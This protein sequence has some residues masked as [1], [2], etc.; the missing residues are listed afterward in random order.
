VLLKV[1]MYIENI[2]IILG[3]Y[4]SGNATVAEVEFLE[5][6]ILKNQQEY[7]EAVK[8]YFLTAQSR[9]HLNAEEAYEKFLGKINEVKVVSIG[10]R[11]L[12]YRILKY[13]ALFVGVSV[14]SFLLYQNLN[15]QGV[16]SPKTAYDKATL[17]L[18]DGTEVVLEEHQNEVLESEDGVKI[19]NKNKV[20][21][22]SAIVAAVKGD[23]TKVAYNTLHVPVGE[24]YQVELPD[25]SK[26]W[27]NSSTSLKFPTKFV[28][29][30]R[31][32]TMDGEA[33]FE[34]EKDKSKPFVV[35]TQTAEVTVL[36]THFNVSAYG[37]DDFFATTL[38]EG[39]VRLDATNQESGKVVLK[40][41]QKGSLLKGNNPAIVVNEVDIYQEIAWKDGKF[42]FEK[43]KLGTIISKLSRW[44]DVDFAL[45]N[46]SLANY[47][48]TGIVL[49]DK[50]VEYLLDIIS[51]TSKVDYEVI[52]K[53]KAN[54]KL[55]K[56][57]KKAAK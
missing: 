47:T 26:V 5:D 42:Y 43:E 44:Y 48:F 6:W 16:A 33:Y 32:V 57:R 31:E 39:S 12:G 45:E 34:I 36:G 37:D 10:K 29:T 9:Q 49:K 41:G 17:V 40:P 50:P 15:K 51:K 23:P 35:K 25:G 19:V 3:K 2:E 8:I 20:L 13:A 46:Q 28:G 14:G 24:I 53:G 21:K 52:K 56:I 18:A 54:R 55:I 1:D 7:S 11:K 4:F 27:M 22:C 30:Q 38:I